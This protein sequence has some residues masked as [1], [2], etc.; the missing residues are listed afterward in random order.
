VKLVIRYAEGDPA[1]GRAGIIHVGMSDERI[2]AGVA[3]VIFGVI[4][5]VASVAGI[6]QCSPED[7]STFGPLC[8]PGMGL[9]IASSFSLFGAG[10]GLTIRGI[11]PTNLTLKF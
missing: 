6:M 11:L 2:G 1:H 4:A 5:S 9:L 3:L 8:V 10:V 7:H